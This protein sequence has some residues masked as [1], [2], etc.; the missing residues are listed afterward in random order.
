[1]I[2]TGPDDTTYTTTPGSRLL[3]PA[4]CRPTAPVDPRVVRAAA[5]HAAVP[6]TL[7]MPRRAQTRADAR[8]QRI[9]HERALNGPYVERRRRLAIPRF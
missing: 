2:W 1:M 5:Q 8:I 9:H 6:V 4:L 3:F 7:P